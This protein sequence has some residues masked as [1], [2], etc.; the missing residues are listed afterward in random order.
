MPLTSP[1]VKAEKLLPV[2]RRA[3]QKT[4]EAQTDPRP[5]S[6][7]MGVAQWELKP[8]EPWSGGERAGGRKRAFTHRSHS[9]VA[10]ANIFSTPFYEKG[11]Q[12]LREAKYIVQGHPA[13]QEQSWNRNPNLRAKLFTVLFL[14]TIPES[15]WLKN[16]QVQNGSGG[17]G[18]A[19]G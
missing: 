4:L 5:L 15:Q 13:T 18:G 11:K 3:P 17:G 6:L 12:R 7:L 16:P 19:G 2:V 9:T 8:R 14:P 10:G 1:P